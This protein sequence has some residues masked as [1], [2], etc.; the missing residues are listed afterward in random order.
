[1]LRGAPIATLGVRH[2]EFRGGPMDLAGSTQVA[3]L[4]SERPGGKDLSIGVMVAGN[5]G[6]LGGAIYKPW[7]ASPE[8]RLQAVHPGHRTQEE[9]IMAAWLV[10]SERTAPQQLRSE[11]DQLRRWAYENM[12]K[13]FL[14]CLHSQWG[15]VE[16][17]VNAFEG[18]IDRAGEPIAPPPEWPHGVRQRWLATRQGVD[19]VN[20]QHEGDYGDAWILPDADLCVDLSDGGTTGWRFFKLN[21]IVRTTLI[22]VAGPNAC[23]ACLRKRSHMMS[24]MLRTQNQRCLDETTNV[25]WVA[26]SGQDVNTYQEAAIEEAAP[27][28]V[29]CVRAA[30][31]AGLDAAIEAGIDVIVLARISGGIYAG[32]WRG[33]MTR[34]FYRKL[35]EDLL[36]EEV[37]VTVASPSIT[38]TASGQDAAPDPQEAAPDANQDTA[39]GQY[40]LE[41]QPG[42]AHDGPPS[43]SRRMDN[44]EE[45]ADQGVEMPCDPHSFSAVECRA[46]PRT[47][48]RGA[49]FQNV[50]MPWID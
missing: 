15:M 33:K 10:G 30:M 17:H 1:M 32:A 31:R 49:F 5:S 50:I 25:V 28:F 9:S 18:F 21:Q 42:S 37:V 14:R 19:Y 22:F 27:F 16:N 3:Y 35:V 4:Y 11:C 41:T 47:M 36:E 12:E 44:G 48:P 29:A 26:S 8:Q 2:L 39:S 7:F 23:H 45:D 24:S 20:T 40:E 13:R 38:P 6:R 34:E 46:M 43:K